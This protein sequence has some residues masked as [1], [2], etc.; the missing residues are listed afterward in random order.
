[1]PGR[2]PDRIA[3]ALCLRAIIKSQ[4]VGGQGVIDLAQA[5]CASALAVISV[6]RGRSGLKS[7]ARGAASLG[8][9]FSMPRPVRRWA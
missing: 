8:L 9:S 1:M 5:R 2:P 4:P 6:V 7:L 3:Q